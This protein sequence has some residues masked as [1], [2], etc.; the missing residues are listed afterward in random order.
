MKRR[1]V[2]QP[3]DNLGTVE[4]LKRDR[5]WLVVDATTGYCVE[6]CDTRARARELARQRNV[7]GVS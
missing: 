1:Y 5:T 6:D 3:M 7:A 4:G 2:V